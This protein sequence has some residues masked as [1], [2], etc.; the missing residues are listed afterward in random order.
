MR[1]IYVLCTALV[2]AG[3]NLPS[4]PK[5]TGAGAL[6][7]YQEQ[8]RPQVHF[9]P[10]QRWMNDPNGMFYYQGEYHLF[11][12]YNPDA[13]VWGPMHWGHAISK[14]LL[15]WE[16]QPIALYPDQLG[17]IFSGSAVV[18]HENTSGLGTKE[19]PPIVAIYTYHDPVGEKQG[20]T[21]F[22]TQGLAYSLDKGRSWI[23]H[24]A[25]PVLANPGIKDFR[26]P[27]VVWH[28]QSKKWIM[29]LAQADHIGFYSSKNLIDWNFESNFGKDWGSHI[30]VWECPDLVL[31]PIEGSEQYKYVLIVSVGSGGPNGGSATQYFVGD[32]DG[33]SFQLDE[34]WQQ[35]LKP[36][37]PVFPQG[38][39]FADFESGIQGWTAVGN[40]FAN[41]PTAGAHPAQ[42][43]VQGF[44]G[45]YL[46][47]SFADKDKATGTLTSRAF[48]IS[49]SYINFMLAG[50][51][52]DGKLGM[53]LL[54]DGKVV[55][56]ATGQN[57]ENFQIHSWDVTDLKGQQAVLQVI[58]EISENWGHIY[59]DQIV[60]SDKPAS[61]KVEP[62]LWLDYGTDNY[63]GVT[64]SAI[65]GE[66]KQSIFMGWMSNWQYAQTV[67]TEVWRSAMTLP[68]Q[69]DLVH[70][71]GLLRLKSTL[72]PELQKLELNKKQFGPLSGR[73]TIALPKP[74]HQSG[75]SRIDLKLEQQQGVSEL[76]LHNQAGDQVK[77]EFD[78]VKKEL[79]LDRRQSGKVDFD[80]HFGNV[81]IAPMM[82]DFSKN[83][84][85]LVL[86]ASS[87]EL[88]WQDGQVVMTALLFPQQPYDSLKLDL[89]KG[90][91]IEQ[92]TLTELKSIWKN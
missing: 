44:E 10:E 53:N 90:S 3:C 86:D 4:T 59:L 43:P 70:S 87:L 80:K 5:N 42:S 72:I 16:H 81:Q 77:I 48:T 83:T 76:I 84:L 56:T 54:V 24:P 58:D 12:Q 45:Q 71:D 22:Q 67:P 50:G 38:Q 33:K 47:N 35:A 31:L 29:V 74:E 46:L 55:R 7:L 51:K 40:A 28:E 8:Y 62:A 66:L 39:I 26:D 73:H 17:T 18:D 63:A 11:Y 34:D 68:R 91:T 61:S 30:G 9:T 88:F 6:P 25:N 32:F 2:L 52:F 13:S 36:E 41:A 75:S 82:G 65:P 49:N 19:N 92:L 64:F 85:T 27:K 79:R 21:D 89:A 57:S 15:H 1:R 37:A 14:D 20:R 78:F 23:K 69:L 60:F